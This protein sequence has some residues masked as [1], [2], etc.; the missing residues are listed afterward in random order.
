MLTE[1]KKGDIGLRK[2]IQGLANVFFN[3]SEISAQEAAWCRLKL[4]MSYSSIA[5]EFINTSEIKKRQKMLKS[6]KEL[7]ELDPELHD[8]LKSVVIQNYADR[9][10]AF[11]TQTTV[12]IGFT[13][14]AKGL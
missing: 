10:D 5:V 14:I 3:C 6:E 4:T 8:V 9:H 13:F 11:Q 2:Q 7:S 1:F 12:S